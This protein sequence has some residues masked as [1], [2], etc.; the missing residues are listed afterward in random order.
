MAVELRNS[1]IHGHGVFACKPFA[2][3]ERIL[4]I[5]DSRVVDD[6]H[7]LDAEAGELDHHCDYLADGRVVL[8]QEPERHIN[9]SCDPNAYVATVEDARVVI[10]RR[11][12]R[13]GEEITYDYIIDCHGGDVWTC[14]CGAAR[15]RGTIVSSVFELPDD[16]L[17]EYLPLLNP[18]FVEEHRE[19]VEAACARLG[20]EF[21]PA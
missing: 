1:P 15:C 20:I 6:A 21:P 18:W 3:G 8:M 13:P 9:S 17:R 11:A 7:P 4:V 16:L 12:L 10:A 14:H 2:A 19:R 5:D